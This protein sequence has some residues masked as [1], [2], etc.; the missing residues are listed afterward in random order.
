MHDSPDF[1][2][3]EL[4]AAVW[5]LSP[6]TPS[7]L[8]YCYTVVMSFAQAFLRSSRATLRQKGNVNPFQQTLGAQ[9]SSQY[10]NSWRN[11]ATAF[12]R[13]KPHV[14][15]GAFSA[16]YRNYLC[17]LADLLQALL[18]TSITARYAMAGA[19]WQ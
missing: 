15:I 17:I 3:I 11:Y 13:N 16:W 8:S 12:E 10:L 2:S 5:Y 7:A 14:N 9:G 4:S 19:V 6:C 1:F 18:A